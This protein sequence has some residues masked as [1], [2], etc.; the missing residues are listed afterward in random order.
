MGGVLLC[1]MIALST[2]FVS[3]HLGGPQLL[4]ALM[5]GLT[6]HFLSNHPGLKPGIDFCGRN[7]LR[8]AVALLGAR[9]SFGQIQTLGW[10]VAVMTITGVL[11][12]IGLGLLLGRLLGRRR[13]EGLISGCAVGICGASAALAVA[14]V[15][16]LTKDNERFTLLAVVGVTVLS[17][18]AMII[19]PLIT[20][21]VG[22]SPAQ[23]G[24]FFGATIHDVAQVVAAGTML[25][26]AGNTAAVD[27]ATVVK[28]MR[29]MMLL[30]TVLVVATAFRKGAATQAI[31]VNGGKPSDPVPLIPGFLLAFIVL[32][33]LNTTGQIPKRLIDLANEL[34]LVF[35]IVAISAAGIKT[36][37][38]DLGRLGMWPVFLLVS[39]TIFLACFAG[40]VLLL[41]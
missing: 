24:I 37:L 28:L 22:F 30:P 19:Y 38:T 26:T 40:V 31:V 14:S 23:A 7:L 8:V 5:F 41:T 2:M 27:N 36:S 32:M 6:F 21:F 10:P 18:L 11:L 25:S 1:A 17:T 13:E 16:P 15:L 4:Y 9:I 39:E 3:E 33:L 29:V 20:Q 34:S 35:L 12:T